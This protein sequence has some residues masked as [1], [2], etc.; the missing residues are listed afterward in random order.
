MGGTRI[1][2]RNQ[3]YSGDMASFT[4]TVQTKVQWR[5]PSV[6]F[7]CRLIAVL[8]LGFV[9]SA[10]VGRSRVCLSEAAPGRAVAATFGSMLS[11][12]NV[13]VTNILTIHFNV[14]H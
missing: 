4:G 8:D 10:S 7:T 5:C 11:V 2:Y 13:E 9:M 12:S 14:L 6:S 3:D 1:S